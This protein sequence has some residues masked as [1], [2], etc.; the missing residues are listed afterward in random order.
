MGDVVLSVWRSP[1]APVF[2]AP[3]PRTAVVDPKRCNLR[4]KPGVPSDERGCG[5]GGRCYLRGRRVPL[6]A[7]RVWGVTVCRVDGW[8]S[9]RMETVRWTCCLPVRCHTKF[10]CVVHFTRALAPHGQRSI[11]SRLLRVVL[12]VQ[13]TSTTRSFGTGTMVA[14]RH[15][16]RRTR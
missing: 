12:A 15:R 4:S 6:T 7:A 3:A 14:T 10:M 13:A 9:S 16:S 1:V 2:A 11:A 8:V 5:K